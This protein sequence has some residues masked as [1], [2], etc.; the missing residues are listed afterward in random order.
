MDPIAKQNV[1][2]SVSI[3]RTLLENLDQHKVCCADLKQI[4]SAKNVL[5]DIAT[6]FEKYYAD[7]HILKRKDLEH[8]LLCREKDL[9]ALEEMTQTAEI[10]RS[11]F[12]D[13]NLRK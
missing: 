12:R 5:F 10:L 2:K 8:L 4:I 3:L 6:L 1:N 9:Q 7:P 13:I 11:L